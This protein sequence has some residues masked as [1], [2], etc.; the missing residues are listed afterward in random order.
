ML[1]KLSGYKTYITGVALI[2]YAVGGVVAGKLDYQKAIETVLLALGLM[3]IRNSIPTGFKRIVEKHT[4]ELK[5]T[6]ETVEEPVDEEA[7][8]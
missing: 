6:D 4:K 7:V 3:G 8:E 2:C 1:K 5:E